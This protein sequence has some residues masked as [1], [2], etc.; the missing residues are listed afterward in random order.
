M[1]LKVVDMQRLE[2]DGDN[3]PRQV[4][5]TTNLYVVKKSVMS[6]PAL[7]TGRETVF[8]RMFK[9]DTGEATQEMFPLVEASAHLMELLVSIFDD[10]FETNR[11]TDR[12]RIAQT[13]KL[14]Y[15]SVAELWSFAA[16]MFRCNVDHRDPRVKKWF[17]M[18]YQSE[19][20]KVIGM[21]VRE[22]E[23]RGWKILLWP[24]WH[25]DSALGFQKVCFYVLSRDQIVL[26]LTSSSPGHTISHL[27]RSRSY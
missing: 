13:E 3:S 10:R 1:I 27:P 16:L 14:I 23:H 18:W 22:D 26:V 24:C 20:G 25:F 9:T 5:R 12:C 15:I 8:R 11:I 4:P 2:G 21:K 17:F 7:D 6:I 19:V